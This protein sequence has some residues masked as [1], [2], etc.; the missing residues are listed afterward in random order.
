MFVSPSCL[1]AFWRMKIYSFGPVLRFQMYAN[2]VSGASNV[3]Y[4]HSVTGL[5]I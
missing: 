1:D 5:G 3:A 4:V 2:T